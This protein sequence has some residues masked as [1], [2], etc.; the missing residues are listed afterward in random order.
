MPSKPSTDWL[1]FSIS[2]AIVLAVCIGLLVD[3]EAGAE[4]LPAIYDRIAGNLG[5]GFLLVGSFL[6]IFLLWLALSE[7]GGVRLG[8]AEEK[9]EFAVL[10][11]AAMLFCAG[12][13]AGLMYWAAIEWAYYLETPP[14]DL[15]PGS[16]AALE[17]ASAYGLFHWGPSA[18]AF[19]CLPTLAIAYPY[20]NR[21]VPF[22]RLSTGC[23]GF[24][25]FKPHRPLGRIVDTIFMVSL[26]GGAGSS[27]G[28]STPMIA[29]LM[30]RILGLENGFHL[31][32]V[33]LVVTIILFGVSA[34]L[35]LK[36]GI[37]R[38]SDLNVALIFLFLGFVLLVG[39]TV[40]LLEAGVTGYGLVLQNFIRLNTWAEPFGDGSFV[41][42]WTIF[43]WAWW[44][45][46]G[47]V[48]GLFVAR[49][50]R[51]RTIRQV[52]Y[53][54][55]G[56]GTIGAGMFFV[57]L[58]NFGLDLELTGAADITG[59]ITSEGGADAI[60]AMLAELPFATVAMTVFCLTA[61]VFS[62]TTYDSASYI[63]A[64]SATRALPAGED[65]ALWQ[66]LFW[67]AMLGA[68]PI[69]LLFVG[70][71]RVVQTATL[72]ASVPVL[73]IGVVMIRSLLKQ[74]A[75][76]HPKRAGRIPHG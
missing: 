36:R 1:A 19:Y 33:V 5:P 59:L 73:A 54:M 64:S 56:Y 57:I 70:G 49:I 7:Y 24:A 46:Y 55:L 50:S 38:L 41:I 34:A 32:V 71:L 43:Y 63:L 6:I 20:Y 51:G 67:A 23:S 12:I 44:V 10:S 25:A 47:P 62:A 3:P 52:I 17:W 31:E 30:A 61:I 66:R 16:M 69:T 21:D 58:G 60:V 18:W 48:V 74:L 15:E 28:F 72:I 75:E 26:L 65:P 37:R 22:L 42:D 2:A 9:P 13:G 39:P 45:A 68:L 27:L 53:G 4:L 11:W 35:G 29:A 8:G 40:R 14:F 76:D